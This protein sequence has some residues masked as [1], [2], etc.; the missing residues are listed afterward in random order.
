MADG[1]RGFLAP[2]VGGAGLD[3]SAAP[4]GYRGML[5]PWMGGAG[6]LGGDTPVGYFGL[7]APWMGGGGYGPAIDAI[8]PDWIVLA[9]R[10]G[11]R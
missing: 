4:A 3:P 7:L 6:S 10:R 5:A 9:R 11:K 2:W 8:T 1:Y